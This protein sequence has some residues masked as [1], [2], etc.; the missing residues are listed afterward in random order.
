MQRVI[1]DDP[2][3]ESVSLRENGTVAVRRGGGRGYW[4]IA[5]ELSPAERRRALQPGRRRAVGAAR[6]QHDRA[7]RVRRQRRRHPLLAATR[8]RD[9]DD[10]RRRPPAEDAPAGHGTQRDDR[11]RPRPRDRR[12]PP[13]LRLRHDR[14]AASEKD[15][16][17]PDIGGNTATPLAAAD[18]SVKP[19]IALSCYGHGDRQD[20]AEKV[21]GLTAGPLVLTG[22]GPESSGRVIETDAIVQAGGAVTV[23]IAPRDR[24][25]AGLLYGRRW[26]GPHRSGRRAP[27]DPFRGLLG[28]HGRGRP[29]PLRGR[30]GDER[31]GL[32]DASCCTC[33]TAASPSAAAWPAGASLQPCSLPSPAVTVRSPSGSPAL[34]RRPRG[35]AALADPQPRSRGRRPR[36]RRRARR[37]RSRARGRGRGRRRDPRCRRG[38]LRRRRRAGERARAQVD[39][40]PRRRRQA[41]RRRQAG[42]H[43]PLRDRQQ[44]GRR[45][46]RARRRHVRHLSAREGQGRRRPAGQRAR[47]H[48]RPA[49]RAHQRPR[50]RPRRI[51]AERS[52][53]GRCR[54]TTSQPCWRPCWAI[55]ATVG[56]TAELVSGDVPVEEAVEAL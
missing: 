1:G 53:A 4:D 43:Q 7:R 12:R 41:D 19:Q 14:R 48:G 25:R 6:R 33:R 16:S 24:D 32:H 38:R 50:H 47:L 13:L 18:G 39:D 9:R 15:K 51:S 35:H 28:Q 8:P 5:I 17:A 46:E 34:L 31:H 21:D 29:R 49:R 20:P 27:H 36:R 56:K 52:T 44:H 54:A 11:R 26:A 23:A 40:G 10:H 2:V 45:R 55:R 42:R 37:L 3:S 22:L 30:P